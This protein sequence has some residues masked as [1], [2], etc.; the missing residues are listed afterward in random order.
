MSFHYA[1]NRHPLRTMLRN[2]NSGHLPTQETFSAE[3]VH[4]TVN[5][6]SSEEENQFSGINPLESSSVWGID[7]YVNA[8]QCVLDHGHA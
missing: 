1:W 2:Y 6:N 4:T 8:L 3:N 7:V 5:S